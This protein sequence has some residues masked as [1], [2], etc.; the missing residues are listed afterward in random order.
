MKY[1]RNLLII[2][3]GILLGSL[4][5]LK[6]NIKITGEELGSIADWFSG[7]IGAIGIL[8]SLW[9]AFSKV[10]INILT[11]LE[12]K[13]CRGCQLIIMNISPNIIELFPVVEK[14]VSIV[15]PDKGI[16]RFNSV[17]DEDESKRTHELQIKF[18]N[19]KFAKL[20]FINIITGKR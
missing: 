8:V 20:T 13:N 15:K 19:H 18:T 14:N 11:A 17:V 3:I 1:L 7:T 9:I 4:V 10:K 5:H 2:L 12:Q 6:L 16:Y